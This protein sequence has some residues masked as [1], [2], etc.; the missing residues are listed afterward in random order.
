MTFKQFNSYD[1]N[2]V[3][4]TS[5]RIVINSK[6]ENIFLAA[7]H[8]I[9]LSAVGSVHIDIGISGKQDANKNVFVVN[10]PNIQFGLPQKG[11]NEHVAKAESVVNF[12]ADISS[13]LSLFSNL[14]E[15]AQAIGMGTASVPSVNAAGSYLKGEINRINKKYGTESSPIISSITKTI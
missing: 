1:K 12:I 3:I 15:S 11:T 13:I 8:D 4:L 9:A 6:G 10:S 7:K 2:Y 5:D 14:L